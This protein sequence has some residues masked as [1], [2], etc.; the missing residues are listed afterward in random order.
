MIELTAEMRATAMAIVDHLAGRAHSPGGQVAQAVDEV[1]TAVLALVERAHDVTPKVPEA[2]G[3]L[4]KDVALIES[5]RFAIPLLTLELLRKPKGSRE[6]TAR[7][8]ISDAVPVIGGRADGLMFRRRSETARDPKRANTFDHL[9][10][11]LAAAAVLHGEV[12]IA[13]L[14]FTSDGTTEAAAPDAVEWTPQPSRPIEVVE[15]P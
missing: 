11:A 4:A 12:T 15:L 1:L 10:R 14:T 3:A 7:G 8:W 6:A 13:G 2:T 5:L 9:A